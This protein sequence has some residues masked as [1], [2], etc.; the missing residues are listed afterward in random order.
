[1]YHRIRDDGFELS[2]KKFTQGG[3]SSKINIFI[4]EA[5]YKAHQMSLEQPEGGNS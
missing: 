1:M 5:D 3:T 2:L 4:I